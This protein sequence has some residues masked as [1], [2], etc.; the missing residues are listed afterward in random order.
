V[1][2]TDNKPKKAQDTTQQVADAPLVEIDV[3]FDLHKVPSWA[4]AG[5]M[6]HNSWAQGKRV[7]EDEL[8]RALDAWRKGP[9]RR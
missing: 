7:S 2:K 1:S 9:V 3:L 6:V 8:L 4:R 5:I